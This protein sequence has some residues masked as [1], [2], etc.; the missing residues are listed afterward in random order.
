[1]TKEWIVSVI[2][3]IGYTLHAITGFGGNIL[4]FP[5]LS[6]LYG[7][8][9]ART[10]LNVIAWV[11]SISVAAD[12]YRDINVK[13]LR[14]ILIW[15]GIGLILGTGM[16][17]HISSDRILMLVYGA[18]IVV[19]ALY[20]LFGH[21]EMNFP[22]P[23]FIAVLLLAGIVQGLFVSGGAFLVIYCARTLKDKKSFR[24]TFTMVWLT[25]YTVMFFWQLIQGRYDKEICIIILFGAVPVLF[26]SWLGSRIVKKVNQRVFMTIVYVLI[27]V[28]GISLMA[29]NL[30]LDLFHG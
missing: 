27:L 19:V 4:V 30:R 11:S 5:V 22:E 15:M 26:A 21:S 23:V 3:F 13:E 7:S 10:S 20:K 25:L 29:S 9:V 28:V 12:S 24:A 18:I 17:S 2:S 8:A 16:V 1:M 14:V 6:A